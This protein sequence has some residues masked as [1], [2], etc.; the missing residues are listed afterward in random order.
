[1]NTSQ[2]KRKLLV[3]D[4]KIDNII[5][6]EAICKIHLKNCV[7]LSSQSGKAGIETARKEQPDAILLDVIMPQMDGYETCHILKT[8]ELTKH[9]PIA[10][11]TATKT[12]TESKVKGLS[13]GA[14]AFLPKPI[15]P[16]ELIAQ[17]SVLFRIKDAEEKLVKKNLYL[18][19][20]IEEKTKSIIESENKYKALYEHA[21]I[22]YQILNNEGTITD[23]NP[24]WLKTLNY[25]KNQVINTKFTNYIHKNYLDNY[26]HVF[27][28]CIKTN[29]PKSSFL[30]LLTSDKNII[31]VNANLVTSTNNEGKIK[32]IYCVFNNIT[33]QI[34]AE[35]KLRKNEKQLKNIMENTSNV[36]YSHDTKNRLTFLSPQIYDLL[37]YTVEEAL[38]NWHKFLSDN[39][40][41]E[42]VEIRTKA[43]IE[44]RLK[45]PPYE[46]EVTHKNG[47]R[48]WAEVREFPIVKNGKTIEISGV[49]TNIT[50]KKYDEN[51][52][53]VIYEIAN[54]SNT[55]KSLYDLIKT[56]QIQLSTIID[57]KNF[58]VA[59]YDKGNKTLSLPF[60]SDEK[61]NIVTIPTGKSLTDYVIRTRKPL[62]ADQKLKEKLIIEG[63][64]ER[65]SSNSKKWLGVPLLVE[66]KVIGV[67]AVQSHT[68]ENAYNED[69][70]RLM[71]I[72]SRQVSLSIHSKKTEQ[73]LMI[74]LEKSKQSERLKTAFLQNISHEIRTPMNGILGFAKLLKIPGL[75]GE[76]QKD[77]IEVIVRSGIRMLNTL[78]D[79]ME[80]SR[81]ETD[82]VKL[83][84]KNINIYESIKSLCNFYL[85]D[86][87]RKNLKIN[88][89]PNTT[90]K[91]IHI[92]ADKEKLEAVISKLVK[93]AIKYSHEGEINISYEITED[94]LK[95]TIEDQGIGIPKDRLEAI[96]ERFIQ[97]D[98]EDSKVYEGSGL[99]LTISKAYV[100]MMGGRIFV[101]SA[102]CKGSKF[103]FT[104]PL[105]YRNSNNSKKKNLPTSI[106]NKAN[107]N[108]KILVAED[109]VIAFEFLNIILSEISSEILHSKDG[110]NAV[111]TC[112]NNPDIDLVL[113]DIKLPGIN[114]YEATKQ[115]RKFNKDVKII[116]QT[117]YAL[118]GDNIKAIDAGCN[119][120]ISKP[121]EKDI[122]LEKIR[123][124]FV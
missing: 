12:D 70:I 75:S 55:S 107:N 23:V 119:D 4:D 103:H 108:Y 113:M 98:I 62:L 83:N 74:A 71:E 78:N 18:E 48:I 86:A 31:D 32:H 121:I 68:D 33:E 69:D 3:I 51:V 94:N 17:V 30:R 49:L 15:D 36:Y 22:S 38:I 21:P 104:I 106:T 77:Y 118:A 40:V 99:G 84:Y 89:L 42:I 124:Q 73:D 116:A 8:N 26:Y 9:I 117:A 66:N 92:T 101:D 105:N 79:L 87:N 24:N 112:K 13:S 95:I 34:K 6:I 123:N 110:E 52:R 16:I 5:S 115:I 88:F 97:A 102:E 29:T 109:E 1:M 7:V 37:G 56:I 44:T 47:E 14:D 93:N 61:D 90:N 114:G 53:K 11:I 54:A 46:I 80:M 60:F 64:I 85:P 10:L 81:L 82:Q 45:Q 96:F 35:R 41:N 59:L 111:N 72:V 76:K 57:T 120:Y 2:Q 39:P 65:F 63:E 100:E 50:Q 43:A 67:M 20:I 19:D 25:A 28:S 122:L 27:S 58:Y 91:D